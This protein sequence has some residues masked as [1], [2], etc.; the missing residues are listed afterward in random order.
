[1]VVFAELEDVALDLLGA[2]GSEVRIWHV[3]ESTESNVRKNVLT[4]VQHIRQTLP[5]HQRHSVVLLGVAQFDEVGGTGRGFVQ[6]VNYTMNVS[7]QDY[8]EQ[9]GKQV[10]HLF[11]VHPS[12]SPRRRDPPS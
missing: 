12:V 7:C 11:P 6:S 3:E 1:M 5:S 4:Q 9:N 8:T 10:T 2:G